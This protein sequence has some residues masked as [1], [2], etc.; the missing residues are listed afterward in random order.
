MRLTAPG[1]RVGYAPFVLRP[2]RLGA[3]RVAV[4]LPTNTWQAYNFRDVGGN[5]VGRHLVRRPGVQ[6]RRPDAAVPAPRRAAALPRLRPRVPPLARPLGPPGGRDRRRRPR[7]ARR[8]AARE[9]LRP[10]R[11]PRPRGVRLD[12]RLGR[13]R[14][15]SR[16]RRQPRAPLGERL[17]L[18]R[19]APRDPPLPDGPLARRRPLGG[20]AARRP[21]VGWFENRYP[22]PALRR[23][24]RR[25]RRRGSFVAPG[26]GTASTFGSYGIEVEPARRG[27]PARHDR[28]RAG[29]GHLRR[30]PLGRDDLLR[31]ADRARRSSRRARSTSAARPSG[32]SSRGCSKTSGTGSPGRR[33]ES[34]AS[35]IASLGAHRHAD[36]RPARD[37]RQRRSVRDQ[38]GP[39]G[40][41]GGDHR[42]PDPAA[43]LLAGLRL[44]RPT[45]SRS[46]SG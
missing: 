35:T 13:D 10:R 9:A 30:G 44:R 38:R 43:C 22:Q 46:P 5:G 32:R 36:P 31:D 27:L 45:A 25:R 37:G 17:L 33:A 24:R 12:A 7:A 14:G 42:R 15:L 19:R 3:S 18:P 39:Q 1:G 20:G 2:R 11:L 26:S 34:A 28:A 6:R 8:R 40:A 29:A 21:Y 23:H 4:V 41:A 16:P